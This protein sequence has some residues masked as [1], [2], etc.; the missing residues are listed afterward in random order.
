MKLF[1]FFFNWLLKM[2]ILPIREVA[3]LK[4][5]I[6]IIGKHFKTQSRSRHRC[7]PGKDQAD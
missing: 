4:P 6:Q 3:S 7:G 1:E 2:L 5:N